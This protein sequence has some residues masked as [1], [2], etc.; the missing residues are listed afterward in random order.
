MTFW[1]KVKYYLYQVG[2]LI[3]Y[4]QALYWREAAKIMREE[5]P[6]LP[7]SVGEMADSAV[8]SI[9]NVFGSIWTWIKIILFGALIIFII[10]LFIGRKK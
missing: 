5:N 9:S 7:P 8:E 6:E 3:P 10:W 2:S 4:G 1:E